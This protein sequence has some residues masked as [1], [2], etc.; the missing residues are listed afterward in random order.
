MKTLLAILTALFAAAAGAQTYPAKPIR[1]IV[2]FPPGG[3]TDIVA[4]LIGQKLTESW[5]QQAIVDNRPGATGMI[6]AQA[7]AKASPT[8]THSAS[9]T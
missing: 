3:G 1:I 2:G 8:V 7:I 5:G 6:G 9:A 4:R